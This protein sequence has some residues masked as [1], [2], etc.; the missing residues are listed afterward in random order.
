[1]RVSKA[2]TALPRPVKRA[3]RKLGTD[4]SIARRRR[5]ITTT[6]MAQRA[7][8]DRRS[9]ARVEKGDPGVS[10]AIYATVL[11]VLGMIDR[12]ADFAS[13]PAND[14]VGNARR[15]K[16]DENSRIPAPSACCRV[17]AMDRDL[18]VY[19]DVGGKAVWV[20]RLWLSE[21][22]TATFR[23]ELDWLQAS[24]AFALS[25]SL[26]LGDGAFH[27]S[28]GNFGAFKRRRPRSVGSKADAAPRT[29]SCS[30]C[31]AASSKR[32]GSRRLPTGRRRPNT[33]WCA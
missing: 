11:F 4:I 14:F 17:E 20:G 21:N 19:M 24:R 2:Q 6:L 18:H 8:I 7:F 29:Q 30:R 3:L 15:R 5:K 16:L 12:L 32:L 31:Q 27:T 10:M 23:Y 1:M 22:G 28:D 9:L 33:P 13:F 26:A 25:P